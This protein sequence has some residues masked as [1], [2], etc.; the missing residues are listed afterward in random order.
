MLL[1]TLDCSRAVPLFW[2]CDLE[3]ALVTCTPQ[4][5]HIL[6]HP[7][8]HVWGFCP[9]KGWFGWVLLG[10]VCISLQFLLC[11]GKVLCESCPGSRRRGL[12]Q[13]LRQEHGLCALT[14]HGKGQVT[15]SHTP[16][17]D[18]WLC[19]VQ[20]AETQNPG[21]LQSAECLPQGGSCGI[22]KWLG[23]FPLMFL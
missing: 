23:F 3:S 9:P 11:R 20:G 8:A 14:L 10:G 4:A 18:R 6:Q 16:G 17:L 5:Q 22:P 12:E 13:F 19:G 7:W 1:S 21:P 2:S 15:L